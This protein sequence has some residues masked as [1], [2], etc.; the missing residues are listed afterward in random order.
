MKESYLF[1]TRF[2]KNPTDIKNFYLFH[3]FIINKFEEP[4]KILPKQ[5]HFLQDN[6]SLLNIIKVWLAR[7][8][9]GADTLEEE[10]ITNS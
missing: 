6:S 3:K 10:H 1:L 9:R 4:H 2:R 5:K 8:P 7:S